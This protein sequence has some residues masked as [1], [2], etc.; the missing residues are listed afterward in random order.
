[1]EIS[2]ASSIDAVFEPKV[3]WI[4]QKNVPSIKKVVFQYDSNSSD[5]ICKYSGYKRYILHTMMQHRFNIN[6]LLYT[7]WAPKT[8]ILRGFLMVNNLVL[9]GPKAFTVF[10]H[11]FFGGANMHGVLYLPV[12][13]TKQ[14]K[15]SHQVLSWS[16]WGMPL[17]TASATSSR[18]TTPQELRRDGMQ[19]PQNAPGGPL[20]GCPVGSAGKRLGISGLVIIIPIYTSFISRSKNPLILT[21]KSWLFN[22]DPYFMVYCNPHITG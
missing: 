22:T 21:V 12:T 16:T 9:G 4:H 3:L 8:Y 10:F 11:G 1:M 5:F 19:R 18:T 17:W 15:S 6:R 13:H 20:L 2:D 7:P 14:L